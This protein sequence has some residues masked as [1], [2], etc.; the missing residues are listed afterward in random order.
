VSNFAQTPDVAERIFNVHVC[1]NAMVLTLSMLRKRNS[2]SLRFRAS[3]TRLGQPCVAL[4]R[5]TGAYQSSPHHGI[6]I[7]SKNSD[8][9]SGVAAARW[10]FGDMRSRTRTGWRC[11]DSEHLEWTR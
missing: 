11:V 1:H 2:V 10:F 8:S 9:P 7:K 5:L 6:R 4:K 3:S